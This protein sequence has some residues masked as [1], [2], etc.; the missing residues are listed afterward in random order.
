[1]DRS[2]TFAFNLESFLQNTDGQALIE[3]DTKSA[4]TTPFNFDFLWF[5]SRRTLCPGV[6][7]SQKGGTPP[8]LGMTPQSENWRLD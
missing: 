5:S 2:D 7:R 4:Y 1:M 3:V 8:G 6:V